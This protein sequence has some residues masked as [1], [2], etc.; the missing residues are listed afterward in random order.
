MQAYTVALNS[1]RGHIFE[2]CLAI[3]CGAHALVP[4]ALPAALMLPYNPSSPSFQAIPPAHP[5]PPNRMAR[6]QHPPTHPA[7]L[8]PLDPASYLRPA[9]PL[10][11]VWM[12][13]NGLS[14]QSV[15]F[16]GFI[17]TMVTSNMV[18]QGR[19]VSNV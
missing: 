2:C 6:P 18:L 15:G 8:H 11:Q 10:L 13:R 12:R 1:K 14:G 17:M 4:A 5:H 19:L 3:F 9:V 7:W 16:S